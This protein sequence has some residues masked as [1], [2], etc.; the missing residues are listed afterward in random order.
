MLRRIFTTQIVSAAD[1]T[2]F[3]LVHSVQV[4][5]LSSLNGRDAVSPPCQ[6]PQPPHQQLM[7]LTTLRHHAFLSVHLA[8]RLTA[9]EW[10]WQTCR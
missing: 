10:L 9:G 4:Y 8:N 2:R 5:T 7:P 1:E 3:C 6:P